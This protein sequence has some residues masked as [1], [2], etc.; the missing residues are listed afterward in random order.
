M[1]FLCIVHVDEE[2]MA[3]LSESEDIALMDAAIEFDDELR[4]RGLLLAAGPLQLP[5]TARVVRV[6]QGKPSVVDGPY[7][8]TKETVG[9]FLLLDVRDMDEAVRLMAEAPI[10]AYTTVEVRAIRERPHS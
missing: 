5:G 7:A 2:K 9:G 4:R 10:A 6:R 1:R 3:R 8:E